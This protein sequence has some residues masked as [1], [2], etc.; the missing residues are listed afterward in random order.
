MASEKKAHDRL[1]GPPQISVFSRTTATDPY[2]ITF[3]LPRGAALFLVSAS[4]SS[5][6]AKND[7]SA[8]YLPEPR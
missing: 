3:T 1:H 8:Q 5:A 7:A 6:V 2:F 4:G